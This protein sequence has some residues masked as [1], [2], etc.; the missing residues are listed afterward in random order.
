MGVYIKDME[1]P[2][3]CKNCQWVEEYGGDY[4]WCY[5]CRHTGKMPLE[6]A[7]KGRDPDCPLVEIKTPHGRLVDEDAI[8]WCYEEEKTHN[9]VVE[10]ARQSGCDSP[11]HQYYDA[12]Y[13]GILTMTGKIRFAP[14]IIEEEV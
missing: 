6:N 4:D 1:M 8:G 11:M 14:T 10:V 7:E 9:K 3:S 5:A 13:D 12:Y 2:E